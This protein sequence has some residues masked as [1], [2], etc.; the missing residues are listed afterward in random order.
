MV[1]LGAGSGDAILRYEHRKSGVPTLDEVSLLN[2]PAS[3][4]PGS[5]RGPLFGD[6][7]Y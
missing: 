3:L 5:L 4:V 1:R 2:Q 6:L 7:I